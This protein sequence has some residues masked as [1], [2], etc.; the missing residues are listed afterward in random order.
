MAARRLS[1]GKMCEELLEQIR[2]G[3][4]APGAV[5]PS[6]HQ[7]AL[8][9]SICRSSVRTGLLSLEQENLVGRQ[10]GKGWFVR[11]AVDSPQFREEMA[12]SRLY[13]I[14]SDLNILTVP[15][16]HQIIFNGI[17]EG[18]K[19]FSARQVFFNTSNLSSIR[20][21]FC[22]GL[23]CAQTGS[24][25]VMQENPFLA[26]LPELG[27][28]PV[29]VN[30]FYENPKIGY[31]SCDYLL[32]AQRGA[33]YLKKLGCQKLC[34]VKTSEIN[35]A[36]SIREH[37]VLRCFAANDIVCCAQPSG[38]TI[39]TYADNFVNW[40]A[41]H[42]IPDTVYLENG[43]FGLPLLRAFQAMGIKPE[44]APRVFCFDD[45]GYLLDFYDYPLLCLRMPLEQ[46]MKDAVQYLVRKT[47]D[48]SY[49]VLKKIYHADIKEYNVE[50]QNNKI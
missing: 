28:L 14:A 39:R 40:F 49:P 43:S 18:C 31:V 45:I 26:R 6:E 13:T 35:R 29:V 41:E 15:W 19:E 37:G 21:G 7:L 47:E 23:I 17:S 4:L 16:Y 3:K 10:A 1:Y 33:E 5:L 44:S 42:G 50:Q 24:F 32:E 8:K 46:M 20:K 27:I 9:Y 12:V 11:V 34:Y 38:E 2:S 22:D 25:N 36:M 30:R 48:S